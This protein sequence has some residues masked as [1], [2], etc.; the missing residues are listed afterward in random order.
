MVRDSSPSV[1]RTRFTRLVKSVAPRLVLSKISLPTTAAAVE[2]VGARQVQARLVQVAGGDL[3]GG[4]A[5]GEL[6]ADAQLVELL[7]DGR[8]VARARRAWR[9]SRT[10]S[11][12]ENRISTKTPT[13]KISTAPTSSRRAG[14]VRP[15]QNPVTLV[16]APIAQPALDLHPAD[17]LPALHK[18]VAHLHRGVERQVGLLHRDERDGRGRRAGRWRPARRG[19]SEPTIWPLRPETALESIA[20]EA[21]VVRGR[22]PCRGGRAASAAA[23][24]AE[25]HGRHG[26]EAG[27]EASG[28][29]R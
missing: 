17:L 2:H 23:D 13:T 25:G 22:R 12:P 6:V 19:C 27:W 15:S 14:P 24:R 5:V 4:A 10:R 26:R 21:G 18:L 9:A 1:A 16:S 3:D 20:G 8:G 29:T 11:A 28:L 7:G